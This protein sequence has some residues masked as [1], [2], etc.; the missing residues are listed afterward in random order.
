MEYIEVDSIKEATHWLAYN[1]KNSV[2]KKTIT[3][4][5]L[6]KF[7][8]IIDSFVNSCGSLVISEEYGI[9]NDRG[10]YCIPYPIH[11]GKL[12]RIDLK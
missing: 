1:D 11:K 8:L 2:S 6:Y 9:K 5:K 10:K 4:W 7:E 3:P 12:I